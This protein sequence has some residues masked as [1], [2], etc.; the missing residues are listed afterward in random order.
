MNRIIPVR[1]AKNRLYRK[2]NLPKPNW[3]TERHLRDAFKRAKRPGANLGDHYN[4]LDSLEKAYERLELPDILSGR[5][6]FV[7]AT[8]ESIA[9]GP[10]ETDDGKKIRAAAAEIVGIETRADSKGA[11]RFQ[12]NDKYVQPHSDFNGRLLEAT[13][14]ESENE[15]MTLYA[16]AKHGAKVA[17][18]AGNQLALVSLGAFSRASSELRQ[19]A[20]FLFA[21]LVDAEK[22]YNRKMMWE[23]IGGLSLES[24]LS[25]REEREERAR[26]FK[27][28]YKIRPEEIES[29]E[30][31]AEVLPTFE[32]DMYLALSDYF[33]SLP[34]IVDRKIEMISGG[35]GYGF[36]NCI[37][38]RKVFNSLHLFRPL[39]E[40]LSF[41]IPQDT[42]LRWKAADQLMALL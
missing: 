24:I 9:T 35:F 38:Q 13:P 12:R 37:T 6:S 8:L 16:I 21:E 28:E 7:K 10:A 25:E 36:G 39:N 30:Q 32:R 29:T 3:R 33:G 23:D 42:E 11:R 31:M 40:R 14:A 18:A 4:L 26:S 17:E 41:I 19:L 27:K 1:L 15:I 20:G 2:I 34:Q 22:T 5:R